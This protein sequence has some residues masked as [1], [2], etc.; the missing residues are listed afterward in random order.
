[1]ARISITSLGCRETSAVH[2]PNPPW[3]FTALTHSE[4]IPAS[5]VVAGRLDPYFQ[6]QRFAVRQPHEIVWAK[7]VNDPVERVRNLKTDV[8]IFYPSAHRVEMAP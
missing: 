5:F 2:S 1:M 7:L 6:N 4:E 8:V 3:P